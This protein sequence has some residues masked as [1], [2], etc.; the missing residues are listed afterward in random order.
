MADRAPGMPAG[1]AAQLTRAALRREFRRLQPL[2]D[3]LR[4]TACL[5]E[6]ADVRAVRRACDDAYALLT[7]QIIP[8]VAAQSVALAAVIDS[9]VSALSRDCRELVTLTH[10]LGVLRSQLSTHSSAEA[11]DD[12]RGVLFGLYALL[13]LQFTKAEEVYLPL[14]DVLC[15]AKP[16]SRDM[17]RPARLPAQARHT[18]AVPALDPGLLVSANGRRTA[19]ERLIAG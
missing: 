6:K 7:T 9:E 14:L 11:A 8:H 18:P 1:R 12:L 17:S 3:G 16:D 19:P 13:R 15:R 2:A 4:R 10:E 5:V